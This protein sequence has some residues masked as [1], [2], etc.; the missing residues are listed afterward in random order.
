MTFVTTHEALTEFL[1]ALSRGGPRLRTE[2]AKRVNQMLS[3]AD[4]RVIPQSSQ[5]FS[6]G[7]ARYQN[8]PDK[9]YSLQDCIS[10]NAMETRGIKQ[11]L[12]SNRH[13][14]QEGFTVLMTRGE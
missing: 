1:T 11:I 4:L 14:Q 13:F 7:L 5:S 10:M 2:A 12:T 6:D 8:R 3:A 9:K